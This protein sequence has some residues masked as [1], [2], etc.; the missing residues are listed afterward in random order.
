MS[1]HFGLV[2]CAAATRKPC[3]ELCSTAEHTAHACCEGAGFTSNFL[4][5]AHMFYKTQC[6]P[7][8]L[9]CRAGD[10][11]CISSAEQWHCAE[12]SWQC[13]SGNDCSRKQQACAGLL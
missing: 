6:T 7:V 5:T 9:S 3:E 10:A 13:S 11:G 12:Q 4:K 1:S 8:D 2:H